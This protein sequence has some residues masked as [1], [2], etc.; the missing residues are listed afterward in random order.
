MKT[1]LG[2][3]SGS[4]LEPCGGWDSPRSF[5]PNQNKPPNG[6]AIFGPWSGSKLYIYSIRVC[7][8]LL[9]GLLSVSKKCV[10]WGIW[11]IVSRDQLHIVS[12]TLLPL[13]ST[14]TERPIFNC[15][16]SQVAWCTPANRP[17]E[18][19]HFRRKILLILSFVD[20]W[21]MNAVS[22]YEIS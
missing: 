7:R 19:M 21:I 22:S 18:D 11:V 17:K 5:R 10:K 12:R 1:H 9:C 2:T 6:C 14:D 15:R 13:Q 16:L 20:F 4:V 3:L 8:F